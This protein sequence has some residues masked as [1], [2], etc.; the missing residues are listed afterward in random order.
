LEVV[1][2]WIEVAV[3][4]LVPTL[5]RCAPLPAASR[6]YAFL[7]RE[8]HHHLRFGQPDECQTARTTLTSVETNG[9]SVFALFIIPPFS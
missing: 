8:T 5:L 2:E 7:S 9:A 3:G 4:S 1:D 6:S